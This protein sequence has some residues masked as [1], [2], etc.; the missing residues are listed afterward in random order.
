MSEQARAILWAQWRTLRNFG[1]RSGRAGLIFS[2]LISAIWY[3]LWI[4]V[5]VAVALLMKESRDS[6]MLYRFL[7]PGLF[8]AVLYWQLIPV[9]MAS[10]GL[11]LELRRLRVYPIPRRQL[12]TI[13]VML[14]VTTASEMLL[15][16]LG[17]AVGLLLNPAFPVWNAFAF[18]P[19]VLF[20]LFL[21]AGI[22]DLLTRLLAYKRFRE[23]ALLALVLLAGLPQLVVM[24]GVPGH[25]RGVIQSLPA[26]PWPWTATARMVTGE[27]TYAN[28]GAMIGWLALSYF[29]A[30]RQFERGLAFD[31]QAARAESAK[32]TKR[33]SWVDWIFHLPGKVFPDPLAAMVEKELRSLIRSSR[34]RMVFL[35]G[36][37]FGLL[38]WLPMA[39]GARGNGVLQQHYLVFVSA[40][41]LLL[42]SEVC[43]WNVFGFDRT[44]AQLYW[45]TP[46][47]P[48]IVLASKNLAAGLFSLLEWAIIAVICFVFRFPLRP[49][50]VVESFA[51]CLLLLVFLAAIGNL[52]SLYFPRPVDPNQNWKRSAAVRFQILLLLLYPLIAVPF[53]FA[54][55][56]RYAWESD[57]AFYGVLGATGLLAAICYGLSLE[58]AA[59]LVRERRETILGLL[60]SGG[61]PVSA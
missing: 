7:A 21:S 4:L 24:M 42:L 60:A 46:V 2:T 32:A 41:A 20:N 25:I 47:R 53:V 49:A 14:R 6:A 61:G 34:F 55:L 16:L 13:E 19:Y 17:A 33:E 8:L 57:W 37:S 59:R 3:S 27:W 51:V 28:A 43:I 35:M 1:P 23:L 36:F 29:F 9:L 10:A 58:S 18:F 50:M 22:R 15:L 31:E 52:S 39:F 44:A 40:Y 11:S 45:L 26:L 38:V 5:A 56:A 48:A 12:F 30:R 54:Y